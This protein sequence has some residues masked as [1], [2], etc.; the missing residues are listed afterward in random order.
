[1]RESLPVYSLKWPTINSVTETKPMRFP[2]KYEKLLQE[3]A[4]KLEASNSNGSDSP[5]SSNVSASEAK[6]R[7]NTAL[8][9]NA[10]RRKDADSHRK[11]LGAVFNV[12]LDFLKE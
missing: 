2:R 12:S 1:M 3:F 6:T 9:N 5:T 10:F 7:Y 8:A 4:Q 11:V